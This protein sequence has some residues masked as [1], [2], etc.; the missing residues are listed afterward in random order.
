MNLTLKTKL[1][2]GFGALLTIIALMGMVGYGGAAATEANSKAVRFNSTKKAL[3]LAVQL[4][5]EKQKVG[6]RDVLLGGKTEYLTAARAEF[7]ENMDALRPLLSTAE[8]K[9]LFT[10]ISQAAES[11]AAI[12]DREIALKNA[13]KTKE[14]LNL[15]YGSGTQQVRADLK[16]YT[17]DLVHWYGKLET[18]S[19]DRQ[20]ASDATTK[21]LLLALVFSGLAVG[22]VI[23]TFIARSISAQVS[24]MLAVIQQIAAN[25]L[26]IDDM[27]VTSQDEIGQA[28]AALNEMKNNLHGIIQT[29][30]GTAEQLAS[31]SEELASTASLQSSGA[32]TQKDQAAQ[33][34][35]AMQEMSA[36]V[37]EVS[38]NSTKA[39]DAARQAADTAR[40]GGVV[41]E[42]TLARMRVIAESVEATAGKIKELGKSSGQ[43]G[44]IIGVI[45]DIA[46][47][48]NLLALNAAIEAARAGEQGRGFAVV[49]DEVRKLAER[50]STATKEIAAMIKNIQDETSSAVTAMESGTRQ[51]EEGVVSTQKSG[52]SLKEIIRMS[53]H[54]GEMITHIATA[55]TEQ[56]A[57][58]E[59]VNRSIAEIAG[60][61]RESASG[62]QQSAHACQDLSGLAFDLQKIVGTF[63]LHGGRSGAPSTGGLP[64]GV[65]SATQ[66]TSAREP[67]PLRRPNAPA[68][69]D[70]NAV[71]AEIN[72]PPSHD[73]D[74]LPM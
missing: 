73:Y 18:E 14:A 8:S 10:D 40:R 32:E 49:A 26:V 69:D 52:E 15:S 62:S 55:A 66:R 30:A 12:A 33:I 41:V 19:L 36:T 22:F 72:A 51:V 59:E 60:L 27:Q 53:E 48:T 35:T 5:I 67:L 44:R 63:K 24:Q 54:V 46:D 42:E 31:A 71:L 34:A 29:I 2:L 58:T 64:A 68:P 65:L 37:T 20:A 21:T 70:Y 17:D 50:S 7:K 25:N 13:G 47:Q 11:Y 56:S 1:A 45:D 4:D 43:I 3:T 39:A 28:G 74:S 6:S 38:D 23:A 16:K 9:K 61:V 57:A